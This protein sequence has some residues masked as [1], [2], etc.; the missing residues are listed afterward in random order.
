[1]ET[2][3]PQN[4]LFEGNTQGITTD[5]LLSN[6]LNDHLICPICEKIYWN[7]QECR[8]C[9][10]VYC[11]PCLKIS[12]E[13]NER[14]PSCKKGAKFGACK[15]LL[16]RLDA[17]QFNCNKGQCSDLMG[18]QDLANHVCPFDT[19]N[20]EI[21]GCTWKGN[22]NNFLNHTQKC[23]CVLIFCPNKCAIQRI[24]RGDI[25]Q[26]REVCLLEKVECP[27]KC[28][29]SCIRKNKKMQMKKHVAD[30][31]PLERLTCCYVGRGCKVHT[32]RSKHAKHIRKCQYQATIMKCKHEVNLKDRT[33][34]KMNCPDYLFKCEGCSVLLVRKDLLKHKCLAFLFQEIELLKD[35]NKKMKEEIEFLKHSRKCKYSKCVKEVEDEEEN[36]KDYVCKKCKKKVCKR[37]IRVTEKGNYCSDCLDVQL[38]LTAVSATSTLQQEEI[39]LENILEENTEQWA[40]KK[41]KEYEKKTAD[42][43][44]IF[45]I[46][47][48][49]EAIISR[50]YIRVNEKYPYGAMKVYVGDFLNIVNQK[51]PGNYEFKKN[52]DGY[53]RITVDIPNVQARFIKI[54]LKEIIDDPNKDG[55]KGYFVLKQ[56]KAFGVICN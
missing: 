32:I 37:Y 1:M 48:D 16:R 2:E 13:K 8:E 26:H 31:C 9:G 11:E 51:L 23:P 53:V 49:K 38:T 19:L 12:L 7:P 54:R 33:E 40:S 6:T 35:E 25:Y 41:H 22:R 3:Y 14:C 43:S 55:T 47:D 46:R 56:F 28:G 17:L 18:Y 44:L 10:I 4:S 34:H 24:K 21:E 45:K 39:S 30:I 36:I 50:L 5:R 42:E 27:N 20:C 15:S 52:K 29:F